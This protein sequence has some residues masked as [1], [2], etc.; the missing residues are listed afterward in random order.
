MEPVERVKQALQSG[1]LTAEELT[2]RRLGELLGKTTSVLYH[3]WGSLDGFLHAVGQAGL[4]DL[5][6]RLAV[7]LRSGGLEGVAVAFVDFGLES[8][9]LYSLMF[10][11]RYDWSAL[12]ASG[13]L[14][15][16]AGLALWTHVVSSFR[17]AGSPAPE[18][19]AR[20]LLAGLHGLVSLAST[21]RA[22]LAATDRSDADVARDTAR[23]LALL[24]M[25][26]SCSQ[27]DSHD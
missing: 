8:P 20:V 26:R 9:A 14:Q 15:A 3:H 4:R 27:E 22:N 18:R 5:G 12:S 19:D 21:G 6:A 2:A 17:A 11:R 24:L 16:S 25:N 1:E 23:H 13:L 7:A 10:E